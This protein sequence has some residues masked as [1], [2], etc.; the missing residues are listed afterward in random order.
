M[1]GIRDT[2]LDA[3]IIASLKEDIGSGDHTSLACIPADSVKTAKLLVKDDGVIAGIAFAR[4]VFRLLD[5]E[6]KFSQLLPDGSDVKYGDIAFE[7]QA[8][9]RVLLQAERLV[10]NT[11]QRLSGIA[12]ISSRFA[13]EVED[14]P[15]TI[16]DTRKTTPL[17]RFL[18][19]W[20]VRIG[21]CDNYRDGL[22]DWIMIK[23]NHVDGC[24]SLTQAINSVHDYMAQHNL[25]LGI[26]VEVRNL[27][28]LHEVLDRGGVTR[29]MLDN[30][31]IPIMREAVATISKR[32]EVEASGGVNLKTVRK[33]AETGVDYISVGALTHSAGCLDLSLKIQK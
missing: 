29:I 27:V 24:G 10:L 32:F 20:A 18:E 4:R 21:G 17:M 12:T 19:K 6:S 26:T 14:L 1:E 23:D 11:M 30:F 16:L 7:I 13:T 9:T 8:N 5:P 28:E 31:E 33:I 22:Y 15:V 2:E 25:K 3:F